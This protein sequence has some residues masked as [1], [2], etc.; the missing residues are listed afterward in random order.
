MADIPERDWRIFRELRALALERFCERALREIDAIASAEGTSWH[1]RYLAVFGLLNRRDD[2][3]ARAFNGANRSK[4]LLQLAAIHSHGLLTRQELDRLTAETRDWLETLS[5][6]RF[7]M[8]DNRNAQLLTPA[9]PKERVRMAL[10]R[11]RELVK[12]Q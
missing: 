12:H 3:W 6:E 1:Q 7:I 2:E 10:T 9:L 5:I 11:C 8:D 4:A